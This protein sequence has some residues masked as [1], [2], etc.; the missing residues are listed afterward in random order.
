[1]NEFLDVLVENALLDN[2][3][4]LL[5]VALSGRASLEEVLT[6][7]RNYRIAGL[8]AL[9]LTGTARECRLR[10]AQSGR[11]YAHH[12]GAAAEAAKL[13]SKAD[14]LFDAIAAGDRDGA[15]AIAR[16]ARHSFAPGEE[17]EEDF[18]FPE[19]VMQRFFLGASDRATAS[20]MDHWEAV[21][22]G[23]ADA[24]LDVCRALQAR[25]ATGFDAALRG[26]LAERLEYWDT[27]AES[28][29]APP[30][31]LETEGSVF[32]EGIAFIRLARGMAL[33]TEREY[34]HVPAIALDDEPL[35]FSADG[36]RQVS[37]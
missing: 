11:A 9:L 26:F 14:P 27:V 22:Q 19:V 6:L 12:L 34:P 35:A 8:G 21:L 13:G 5:P 20:L 29:R 7:C 37:V 33:A 28:N 18:L 1:M 25:D 17:F 2:E 23:S 4:D 36:W 15:A 10:L 30:E 31:V 24:R 3:E 16:H 32:V